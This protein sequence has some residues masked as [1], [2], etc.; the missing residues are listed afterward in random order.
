MYKLMGILKRPEG[1]EMDAF[2]RWWL[3]EHA[4]KVKQWPGLVRYCINLS[5]SDDQRYDGIAE[6]W[7]E[8]RED[9]DRI[10]ETAEG[11]RARTSATDGAS[12]LEILL[13]EENVMVD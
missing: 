5:T 9:M 7:F 12:E 1:M 8:K 13:T 4:A 2:R 10:F 3:E 11:Q 6:V